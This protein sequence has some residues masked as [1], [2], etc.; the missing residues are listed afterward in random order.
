MLVIIAGTRHK[1][2][3]K[4]LDE[5]IEESGFDITGV[6]SG[7][8]EGVDALG[9]EWARSRKMPVEVF[10]AQW[11][12]Y[13]KAAGPKRNQQMANIGE[14]LIALP[15]QHSKGT[16]DMIRKAENRP[17]R[18]MPVYVKEVKCQTGQK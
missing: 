18:P 3:P 12:N 6:V 7:G 14:A 2:D 1:I 5:A 13:G 9:E 11:D 16:R 4:L 15:C 17:I 10:E 8:G